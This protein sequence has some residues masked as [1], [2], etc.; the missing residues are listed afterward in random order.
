[1]SR[2]EARE[3]LS[4]RQQDDWVDGRIQL[5]VEARETCSGTRIGRSTEHGYAE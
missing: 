3:L 5:Y 1:M 2:V 4:A